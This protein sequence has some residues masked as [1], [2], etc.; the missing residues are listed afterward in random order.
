MKKIIQLSAI[1]MLGACVYG[2]PINYEKFYTNA[3]ITKVDWTKVDGQGSSC[4]TN[5]F[6]GLLPF[7]DNSVAV[8]VENAEI[9][10][11]SYIDTDSVLYLPLLMSRECTN[12]WGELTPEARAAEAYRAKAEAENEAEDEEESKTSDYMMPQPVKATPAKPAP[13]KPAVAKPVP[14][15]TE[16]AQKAQQ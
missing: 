16:V 4:Q 1:L 12:V 8:A 14:A 3:D 11:I 2:N 6:F 5:W 15:K 7:G 10:R 13:A 9:A